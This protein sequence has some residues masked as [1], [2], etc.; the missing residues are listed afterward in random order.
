MR[1]ERSEGNKVAA[2]QKENV[3]QQLGEH[4]P[5]RVSRLR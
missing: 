1:E 5:R 3:V 4:G 2:P